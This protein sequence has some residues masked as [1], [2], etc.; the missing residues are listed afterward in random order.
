MPI[1]KRCGHQ[2][3]YYTMPEPARPSCSTS[4]HNPKVH[5][6]YTLDV[7]AFNHR[8]RISSTQ[9]ILALAPVQQIYTAPIRIL[10]RLE[11]SYP[12]TLPSALSRMHHGELLFLSLV[13]LELAAA[14]QQVQSGR[15]DLYHEKGAT[16]R[17][18]SAT[19]A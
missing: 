4:E 19:L 7:P 3:V 18:G 15:C 16:Q 12:N 8:N 6:L 10:S 17:Q 14:N 9:L 2:V 11:A 1:P 13:K 5:Y